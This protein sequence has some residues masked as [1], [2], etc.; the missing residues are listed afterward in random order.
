M[1]QLVRIVS[2]EARP[3]DPAAAEVTASGTYVNAYVVA[4]SDA[5]AVACALHEIEAA[6]W[7]ACEPAA[8]QLI[9][10]ST[11]EAGSDGLAYYEQCLIDGVVLVMHTWRHEH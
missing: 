10:P 7:V 1:Q 6:G 11:L 2:M 8:S 4:A 3:L 5:A 9:D